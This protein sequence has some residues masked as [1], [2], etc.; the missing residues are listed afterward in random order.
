MK[1][2]KDFMFQLTK[3]EFKNLIFQFGTSSWEETTTQGFGVEIGRVSQ[4]L[5]ETCR[6]GG[7]NFELL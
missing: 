6:K 1:F 3:K 2:L 7:L 5:L 4:V